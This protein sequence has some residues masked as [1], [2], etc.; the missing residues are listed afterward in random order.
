MRVCVCVC[1]VCKGVEYVRMRVCVCVCRVCVLHAGVCTCVECGCVN[2]CMCLGVCV[3]VLDYEVHVGE[4][5]GDEEG[6]GG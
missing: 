4:R 5:E 6:G 1:T 3:C 2:V